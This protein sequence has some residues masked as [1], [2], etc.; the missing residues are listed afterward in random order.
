M[1]RIR[2]GLTVMR[3][4]RRPCP[5]E[6]IAGKRS[7]GSKKARTFR[8]TS[9]LDGTLLSAIPKTVSFETVAP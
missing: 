5:T 4:I 3:G 6:F 9:L 2:E 8:E 7:E 1:E